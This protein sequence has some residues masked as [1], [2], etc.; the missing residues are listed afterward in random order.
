MSRKISFT[1]VGSS[2]TEN[3]DFGNGN[4]FTLPDGAVIMVDGVIIAAGGSAPP[5]PPPGPLPPPAPPAPGPVPVGVEVVVIAWPKN[6][7]SQTL[8]RPQLSNFGKQIKALKITAPADIGTETKVGSIATAEM[9]AQATFREMTVSNNPG[10]F[11]SGNF[12][13]NGIGSPDLEPGGTYSINDPQFRSHGHLFD[14]VAGQTIYFNLRNL[15]LPD[16]QTADMFCD[17]RPPVK[18]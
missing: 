15:G 4:E 8:P 5:Q 1:N 7:E 11:T 3:P 16:G 17:F 2:I 12:I 14:L 10:D 13:F 18:Q 6:G 9:N